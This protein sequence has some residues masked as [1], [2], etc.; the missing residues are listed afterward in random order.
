[1]SMLYRHVYVLNECEFSSEGNRNWGS[2]YYISET[3]EQKKKEGM[4]RAANG[5]PIEESLEGMT[6]TGFHT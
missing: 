6:S 4:E 3:N 5:I 1:M 2:S